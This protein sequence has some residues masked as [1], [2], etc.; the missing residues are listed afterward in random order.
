MTNTGNGAPWFTVS[1]KIAGGN[2]GMHMF[3]TGWLH[4]QTQ[5]NGETNCTPIVLMVENTLEHSFKNCTITTQT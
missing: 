1:H 2:M 5:S 3:N 4:C